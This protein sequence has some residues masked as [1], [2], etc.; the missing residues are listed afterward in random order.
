MSGGPLVGLEVQVS[1]VLDYKYVDHWEQNNLVELVR[2]TKQ[3]D[4]VPPR[5]W[6]FHEFRSF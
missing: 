3:R 6:G 4:Y 2:H 5:L 1:E